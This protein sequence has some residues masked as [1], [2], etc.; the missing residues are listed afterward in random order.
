MKGALPLGIVVDANV[1]KA[2]SFFLLFIGL[3][4]KFVDWIQTC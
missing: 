4:Q 3:M 2:R 1:D